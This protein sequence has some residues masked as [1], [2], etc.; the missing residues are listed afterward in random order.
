MMNNISK[1]GP[2]LD[3]D[4][5]SSYDGFYFS[6]VV[7]RSKPAPYVDPEQKLYDAVVDGDLTTMQQ[8]MRSL[9]LQVDQ[10]VKG[11][12]NLL[13]LAC[14]EGH[15]KIVEWLVER[16][17]ANVN[18]QLDSVTPLMMACSTTHKDSC[19]V[20]RIV[21]LLL[22]HGA[23]INVS[24][25][26]GMTPL[27]FASQNGFV[28]VVRLLIKDVSFDAVDNQGCTAIFHA[29]E[30][31]HVEVVKLLVEAGA[32]ATIARNKGYPPIQ[33]AMSEKMCILYLLP[34]LEQVL[35]L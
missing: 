3:S 30:K 29:I 25:K 11:G 27:M 20:E 22:R 26:Y 8:E 12:L 6:D 2:P 7:K 1:Y 17:G 33:V 28:G 23:V 35:K 31:N 4:S 18:R 19:V 9:V 32:N 5:D 14:R 24:D 15:N 21:G 10:P 13:M 16:A 34:L